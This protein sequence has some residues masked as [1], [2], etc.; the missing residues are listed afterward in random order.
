[1]SVIM[2]LCLQK[3]TMSS[4]KLLC[5]SV[6]YY[7]IMSSKRYYVFKKL[8][9]YYVCY[10]ISLNSSSKRRNEPGS[11]GACGSCTQHS[12]TSRYI[13]A[14]SEKVLGGPTR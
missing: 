13:A 1:M 6:C 4:K 3:D 5:Y 14:T 12:G 9:C 2:L 7:V 8:L 10:T 11:S